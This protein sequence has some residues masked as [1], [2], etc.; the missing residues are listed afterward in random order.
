[1]IK[2]VIQALGTITSMILSFIALRVSQNNHDLGMLYDSPQSVLAD[3]LLF[4]SLIV[5]IFTGI[6]Y[7]KS[8]DEQDGV[9]ILLYGALGLVHV[10][11][12][13]I[14]IMVAGLKID[15]G[16]Y[17]WAVFLGIICLIILG[18]KTPQS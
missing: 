12:G 16:Q 13:P 5:M 9:H 10:I 6:S 8:K 11:L 15:F 2:F 3:G 1:M 14:A 7:W 4:A 17:W 18:R